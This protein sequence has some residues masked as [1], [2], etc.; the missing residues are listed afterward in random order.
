MQ[1]EIKY[2]LSDWK[3]FQS[4]IEKTVYT[5]K[6]QW[7]ESIWVNSIFWL[8]AVYIFLTIFQSGRSF[9]WPTA[10]VVTF[11]FVLYFVQIL[12]NGAKA[13]RACQPMYGGSFL[14]NHM[15]EIDE[16]GIGVKGDYYESKYKWNSVK[17]VEKTEKV[18]YLFIDSINAFIF[19]LSRIP[20]LEVFESLINE[21]VKRPLD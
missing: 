8:I 21:Y 1:I 19:P 6:K 9:S 2:E 5:E 16:T 18:I 11:V 14:A 4:F 10:G 17:R 3:E 15:F 12:L 7:W 13:K 20:N